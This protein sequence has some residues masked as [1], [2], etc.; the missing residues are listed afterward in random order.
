MDYDEM[1]HIFTHEDIQKLERAQ[2]RKESQPLSEKNIEQECDR[3]IFKANMSLIWAVETKKDTKIVELKTLGCVA[4]CVM[5]R[6][7]EGGYTPI[8]QYFDAKW[9]TLVFK[10]DEKDS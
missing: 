1:T 5:A 4:P 6:M 10:R 7:R 9:T 2:A 3:T 8:G